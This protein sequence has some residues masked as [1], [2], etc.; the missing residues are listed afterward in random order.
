MLEMPRPLGRGVTSDDELRNL[1]P[2]RFTN[3]SSLPPLIEGQTSAI[4]TW[5]IWHGLTATSGVTV[6]TD[7]GLNGTNPGRPALHLNSKGLANTV[8][9]TFGLGDVTDPAGSGPP[10]SWDFRYAWLRAIYRTYFGLQ[11]RVDLTGPGASYVYHSMRLC[12]NGSVLVG[13]ANGVT[14]T[15]SVSLSAPDLF[16]G[17][18]VE[19]LTSGGVI[20]AN[21]DGLFTVEIPGDGLVLLYAYNEA[22]GPGQSLVNTNVN[23]IWIESAPLL[24]WPSATNWDLRVGFDLRDTGCELSVSFE[25]VTPPKAFAQTPS[26]PVSGGGSS[27]VS[28]L[29]PDPDLNDPF[30]VSTTDGAQYQFRAYLHKDGVL[31]SEVSV[32]VRLAWAVRPLS[33]PTEILPGSTH[34]VTFE[35]EDLPG[36]LPGEEGVPMDRVSLWQPYLASQQQYQIGFQLLSAGQ[37]AFHDEVL[38][39][40]GNGTFSFDVAV[41]QNALG[42]FTWQAWIRPVSDVSFDVLDGFEDR[43]TGTNAPS[44]PQLSAPWS[45]Y[46]YAHNK[47]AEPTM[48]W[49]AGVDKDS[50]EGV[51]AA[52]GIVTNPPSVGLFSGAYIIKSNAQPWALPYDRR[53]WANWTFAADV[54]EKQSLPCTLELQI[55]DARRGQIHFTKPY[56]PGA[57]GWDTIEASLDRFV[58]PEWVG[59]FDSSTVSELVVNVQVLQTNTVYH[60]SYDNIRLRGPETTTPS[61]PEHDLWD[62]FDDRN[63]GT[64]EEFLLPWRSY[65]Y[66]QSGNAQKTAVGIGS[67]AADGG[68][69]AFLIVTNPPDV[70][71]YSGFG[72]V[73]DLTNSLSLPASREEWKNY[74]FRFDFKELDGRPCILELKLES[75]DNNYIHFTHQYSP[76][77][78]LWDRVQAALDQFVTPAESDPFDAARVLRLVANVQMLEPGETYE[79]YFDNIHFDA[80]DQPLPQAPI[81]ASYTSS[82]DSLIIERVWPEPGGFI[83]FSWSGVAVVQ[84]ATDAAGPGLMWHRPRTSSESRR[85]AREAFTACIGDGGQ[86]L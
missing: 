6:V 47:E 71:R 65:A 26:L 54:K 15:A 19:N 16:H 35:W 28:L 67:V 21:S 78:N 60:I 12:A 29:V 51:R 50:S 27:V 7:R 34:R 63:G 66:P 68:H 11:P 72:L 81:L 9:N 48:Y 38:T 52:F 76:D 8:I 32:P 57:D 86:V 56:A 85:R 22:P 79:G 36:W 39:S 45:F 17:K 77:P 53:E 84:S 33:L 61:V 74:S 80:P 4:R 75:G 3:A 18:T 13:L 64:D 25:R 40:I 44:S 24:V 58:S 5:K 31:L 2:L 83:A 10:H 70:G 37:P 23:K 41:P 42:P 62:G 20:E 82:D 14:S 30:Y 46:P 49:D 73:Y 43:D 59:F 1:A 55:K 69:A